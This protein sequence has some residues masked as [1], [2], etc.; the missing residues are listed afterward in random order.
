MSGM[1]LHTLGMVGSHQDEH[2]LFKADVPV[3]N[4][5]AT[6]V[7]VTVVR[8]GL[9]ETMI[10]AKTW[11]DRQRVITAKDDEYENE[12]LAL[13]AMHR[14]CIASAIAM[15]THKSRSITTKKPGILRQYHNYE[16]GP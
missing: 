13:C 8:T 5:N 2:G 10:A 14:I 3:E 1:G 15:G 9:A 4:C 7:A 6:S 11:L 12:K 16:W